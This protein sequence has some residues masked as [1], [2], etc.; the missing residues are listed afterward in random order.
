MTRQVGW[1]RLIE[2]FQWI[3]IHTRFLVGRCIRLV[4]APTAPHCA[5]C[6]WRSP[7]KEGKDGA[8]TAPP[9]FSLKG[10]AVVKVA[11]LVAIM[12]GPFQVLRHT[13]PG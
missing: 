7:E 10:G 13:A 11:R 2:G 12:T 3:G 5:D 9:F 8:A 6:F 1:S 4:I